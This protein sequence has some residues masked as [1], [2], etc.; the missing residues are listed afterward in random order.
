M[1]KMADTPLTEQLAALD[2][3]LEAANERQRIAQRRS[4]CEAEV[5]TRATAELRAYRDA[6]TFKQ[7]EPDSAEARRLTYELFDRI[8]QRGLVLES[9]GGGTLIVRDP[10]IRQEYEAALAA[11][12]KARAARRRFAAEHGDGLA[13]ERQ[14]AEGERLREAIESGNTA[15]AKEV[16]AGA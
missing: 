9:A 4:E 10:A 7:R 12:S 6:V 1:R 2:A 14:L 13:A 15:A 11:R 16:L 5:S 8:R 3:A